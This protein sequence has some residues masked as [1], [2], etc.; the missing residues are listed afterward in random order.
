MYIRY[1]ANTFNK[2]EDFKDE[3]INIPIADCEQSLGN[4]YFTVS[5]L[6]YGIL[7]FQIQRKK[8]KN[9]L[10]CK[11]AITCAVSWKKEKSLVD[12]EGASLWF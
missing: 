11:R 1:K 4:F 6:Y 2:I 8:N 10:K 12:T 5:L 7:R 3:H 9:N